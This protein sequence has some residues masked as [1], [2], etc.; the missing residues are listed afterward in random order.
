MLMKYAVTSSGKTIE[1]SIDLSFGRCEYIVTYDTE[2]KT[3]SSFPN[4]FKNE[5][6]GVGPALVE[7]LHNKG[8]QKVISGSF[9]IKIK[10]LMDSKH[11]QMI[12]PKEEDLTV[13]SVIDLIERR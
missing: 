2:T 11:I 7:F 1:S 9:G 13:A 10:D 3:I 8:V 6:E 12:I 5:D 4:P